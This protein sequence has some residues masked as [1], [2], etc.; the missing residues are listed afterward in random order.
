[1]WLFVDQDFFALGTFAKEETK[2][3][4]ER[5]SMSSLALDYTY[6]YPFASTLTAT[7]EQP[8]LRLATCGGAAD[9][10]Y[11]FKGRLT[12]PRRT[13]DLLRGLVRIVQSRF[14]IPPALLQRILLAAD[15]VVTAC[16]DILRLEVFSACCST[17]ARVDL[18]P[19]AMD[20]ENFSRGT[21]NVDFNAPMRA[22]LAKIRDADQVVLSVGADALTLEKAAHQVVERKVSLPLRWLKGFV[23]VQAYQAR[24]NR[25]L[26]VAGPEAHRFFRS[27]PRR[28]LR[29]SCWV[30]PAGRGLRLS[31]SA[32]KD[33]VCVGGIQRL[34][35]LENLAREARRLRIYA[36]PVTQT[37]AWE[38][39]FPEARF[40]LVLSPEVW[41]GFSGEG[42]VLTALAQKKWEQTLPHVRAALK[43]ESTIDPVVLSNR[44]GAPIDA[45]TAALTTLGSRGLVGY[46]LAEGAYFQRELP[47]DLSR[48][49]ALQPRLQ[50]ARK[51]IAGGGIVVI[52]RAPDYL[53]ALVPGSGVEHRVR[54]TSADSRCTCPWFA[55]HQGMRGPCKHVLAL[56]ILEDDKSETTPCP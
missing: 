8:R 27:L 20:G 43:W 21:T 6:R 47:F 38:L 34:S 28:N 1:M 42:Q 2:R 18:L 7:G 37:S 11:F 51:L 24:M 3:L 50:D 5:S 16:E 29:Q 54:L 49:Q 53:E 4:R 52:R 30:V 17:Y 26:E 39:V 44:C 25:C 22:A 55:K 41:R 13:A 45:I 33:G 14:H 10:P 9:H 19:P 48:I 46:D 12:Q 23:E 40:F 15:P 36:E 56:E 32:A 31:Q 35:A